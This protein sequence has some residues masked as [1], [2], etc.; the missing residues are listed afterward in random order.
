MTCPSP[1]RTENCSQTY[2]CGWCPPLSC[3]ILMG[4]D[5]R[6]PTS[7]PCPRSMPTTLKEAARLPSRW[8]KPPVL[9]SSN[10]TVDNG[11]IREVGRDDITPQGWIR[12]LP[13]HVGR[14]RRLFCPLCTAGKQQLSINITLVNLQMDFLLSVLVSQPSTEGV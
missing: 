10:P 2:G 6:V 5:I 8:M 3:G 13:P 14:E 9:C 1:R 12:V 4:E 7:P 11:Y